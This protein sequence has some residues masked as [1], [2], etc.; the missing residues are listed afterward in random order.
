MVIE[1][2]EERMPEICSIKRKLQALEGVKIFMEPQQI[3]YPGFFL[4]MLQ[5]K[6][7]VEEKEVLLTAR[8]FDILT[9]MAR[10]PGRVYT[11]AQICRMIYGET[12]VGEETYNNIYCLIGSLRKKLVRR[13]Q[14]S[15]YLHTVH[16]VGYRFE[17]N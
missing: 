7:M 5:R 13:L 17:I 1:F 14:D 4:D 9:V 2:P 11:Y 6:V 3:R 8:E 10:H 15:G 12:D 16:G